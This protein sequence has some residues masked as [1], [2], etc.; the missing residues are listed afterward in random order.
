MRGLRLDDFGHPL[1]R[2]DRLYGRRLAAL[3]LELVQFDEKVSHDL[4]VLAVDVQ[5]PLLVE[6]VLLAAEDASLAVQHHADLV[7][8]VAHV[9]VDV[10]G[11]E[12]LPDLA[13]RLRVQAFFALGPRRRKLFARRLVWGWGI[14]LLLFLGCY[15]VHRQLGS[16]F[17][18]LLVFFLLFVL[19]F[20]VVGPHTLEERRD[21]VTI[22]ALLNNLTE[23]CQDDSVVAVLRSLGSALL[24]EPVLSFGKVGTGCMLGLVF[25]R[26]HICRP[27]KLVRVEL[28]F[29]P[30]LP[31][32][33]FLLLDHLRVIGESILVTGLIFEVLSHALQRAQL[34][35]HIVELPPRLVRRIL[36]EAH[37]L[38]I[39]QDR[40]V[41]LVLQAAV[42]DSG[43]VIIHEAQFVVIVLDP[44]G[45]GRHLCVLD[46]GSL[47]L[48][49][50]V[51]KSVQE[52]NLDEDP[53]EEG[54][55]VIVAEADHAPQCILLVVFLF[56]PPAG[57][58]R[59]SRH[60]SM[61]VELAG[62][63]DL[64]Y[65]DE[66]FQDACSVW[67]PIRPVETEGEDFGEL[68]GLARI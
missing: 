39:E 52:A 56:L 19:P 41:R 15:L 26:S 28:T 48:D 51:V 31:F 53:S 42:Q 8:L 4:I 23:A 62:A 3:Q 6:V 67:A 22:A 63:E 46:L 10:E 5:S 2:T 47:F 12:L 30:D 68:V 45:L 21:E 27:E 60:H 44:L 65:R 17:F 49:P 18:I 40:R 13:Q 32:D 50:R 36:F 37:Q 9:H 14:F 25:L 61:L 29:Y 24:L 59:V 34:H 7:T 20:P 55:V 64:W 43:P 35:L 38:L 54:E 33:R 66:R 16:G 1:P 57:G 11:L 58:G